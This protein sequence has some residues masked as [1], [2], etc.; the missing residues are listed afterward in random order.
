MEIRRPAAAARAIAEVTSDDRRGDDE[1][2]E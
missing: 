1:T 2:R